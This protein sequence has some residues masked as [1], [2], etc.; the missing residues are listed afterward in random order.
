MKRTI[1]ATE[2]LSIG[3]WLGT[4]A[5]FAQSPGKSK[6][7]DEKQPVVTDNAARMPNPDTMTAA[8][9]HKHCKEMMQ[10]PKDISRDALLGK[11]PKLIEQIQDREAR[12][13]A[14]A[15]R[16]AEIKGMPDPDTLSVEALRQHCKDMMK[17]PADT[18]KGKFGP[19]YQKGHKGY[20]K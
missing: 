7:L 13:K 17:K 8:E 4:G 14:A 3:L 19:H 18:S 9:M 12:K 1:L 20:D 10:E 11:Y 15:D 6:L 2:I 5:V 16:S